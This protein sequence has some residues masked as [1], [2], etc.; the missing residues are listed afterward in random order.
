ME[1]V[2]ER[3]LRPG[4]ENLGSLE[5]AELL[6]LY[7]DRVHYD[8]N[9][10]SDAKA[11]ARQ[12]FGVR[13]PRRNDHDRDG[14]GCNR[15]N[16]KN[17]RPARE[18]AASR[19]TLAKD[20]TKDSSKGKAEA[21]TFRQTRP[22]DW[23]PRRAG[24]RQ[25]RFED[26]YAYMGVPFKRRFTGVAGMS[27]TPSAPLPHNAFRRVRRTMK[28]PTYFTAYAE[29]KAPWRSELMRGSIEALYGT[30]DLGAKVL[31]LLTTSLTAST[32][33]NYEGKDRL[34][35]EFRIDEASPFMLA[36]MRGN[37]PFLRRFV[38][39]RDAA[40]RASPSAK[41]PDRFWALPGDGATPTLTW[42]AATL[43]DWLKR[44]VGRINRAYP[45]GYM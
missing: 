26:T 25:L 33:S 17:A 42:K 30:D 32:S 2:R 20:V 35:A 10:A 14:G 19:T 11:S 41:Q 12:R 18:T 23:V 9:I 43:G 3:Y 8:A 13:G 31:D 34:F 1:V 37:V 36:P 39:Y 24:P 22:N 16:F 5:V 21:P 29:A 28:T 27:G 6:E 4:I 40:F 7:K 44:A 38:I 15:D 45:E